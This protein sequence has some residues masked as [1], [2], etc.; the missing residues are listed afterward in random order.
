MLQQTQ[1]ER[2]V[3]FYRAF[4]KKF[5][6]FARLA[7][8][9]QREVLRAWSGL[10]YNRRALN[11]HRAAAIVSERYGGRLPRTQ[12]GLE[13]LP[14]VGA[15]TASAVR[16][17]A[18]NEPVAMIETNIRTVFIH[19]YDFLHK[20]II[21]PRQKKQKAH[22]RREL[23]DREL[24]RYIV[25][26]V[27]ERNPREW[28]Y[29]LMDYGMHL[30]KTAGNASRKSVYYTKQPPFRGS[31][32]ELRGNILKALTKKSCAPA[33]LARALGVPK[34]K[35]A[36]SLATLEREGFITRRRGTLALA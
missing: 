1:A 12:T 2:V 9:P 34:K 3:P 31:S 18:F 8:S 26:T 29:A 30:K 32:R 13:A 7:A 20:M 27:D 35:L 28:Y 16:A 36:L 21:N 4:V 22:G 33:A 10:G 19:H 6:S 15:Y 11:L 17:F 24:L 5:P 14:G 23:H 25:V